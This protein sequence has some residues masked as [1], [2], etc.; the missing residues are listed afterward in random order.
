MSTDIL[1]SL[2]SLADSYGSPVHDGEETSGNFAVIEN[3]H[4]KG[5]GRWCEWAEKSRVV[6]NSVA[7]TLRSFAHNLQ[8]EVRLF[9]K[10]LTAYHH[11][12]VYFFPLE[13]ELNS[14]YFWKV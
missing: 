9:W 14:P 10:R 3:E 8:V 12:F 1:M 5:S 7:F 11:P 4:S 13:L 6:P 2:S